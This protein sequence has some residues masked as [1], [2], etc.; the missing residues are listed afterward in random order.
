MSNPFGECVGWVVRG[1]DNAPPPQWVQS[2]SALFEQ[3]EA[4]STNAGHSPSSSLFLV[5]FGIVVF[6]ACLFGIVALFLNRCTRNLNK[7]K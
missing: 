6:N 2:G 3:L 1:C 7:E 5:A 4:P